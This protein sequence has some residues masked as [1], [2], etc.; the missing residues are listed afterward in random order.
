MA[1]DFLKLFTDVFHPESGERVLVVTDGPREGVD[2]SAAWRERREMAAR[3]RTLRTIWR[4][5][6]FRS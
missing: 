1:F 3:W 5:K 6:S 2:D 4:S